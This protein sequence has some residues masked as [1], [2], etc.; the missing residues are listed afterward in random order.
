MKISNIPMCGAQCFFGCKVFANMQT[1]KQKGNITRQHSHFSKEN[2]PNL[3]KN[4]MF[5][6]VWTSILIW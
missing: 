5:R 4:L 3:E 6:H 1:I 2:P